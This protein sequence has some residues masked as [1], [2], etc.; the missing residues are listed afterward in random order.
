MLTEGVWAEVKVDNEHLRLFSEHNAQG[1]QASVLDLDDG[2]AGEW[3]DL[4]F[5]VQHEICGSNERIGQI[6]EIIQ[7]AEVWPSSR[8]W[9]IR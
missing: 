8:I 2:F 7:D 5:R 4:L 1:V 3:V 6:N 9:Q